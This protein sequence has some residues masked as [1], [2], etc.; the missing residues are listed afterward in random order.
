MVGKT[1]EKQRAYARQWQKDNRTRYLAIKKK[2]RENNKEKLAAYSKDYNTRNKNKKRTKH[3]LNR[4][5]LSPEDYQN[6]LDKQKGRCAICSTDDPGRGEVFFLVD[7]CHLTKKVRGLLC[8]NCNKGLGH[9][10]DSFSILTKA[11]K[12][13]NDC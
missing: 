13:L 12:Y 9:F 6:L 5:G 8:D 4:Y 7:H 1:T 2:Y 10:K 11:I 3:L